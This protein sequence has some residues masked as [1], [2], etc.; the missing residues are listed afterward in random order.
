MKSADAKAYSRYGLRDGPQQ[1][2]DVAAQRFAI[3]ARSSAD[4]CST[5]GLP[6]SMTEPLDLHECVYL[7][8]DT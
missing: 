4:G 2:V 7:T 3:F 1:D 6:R 8:A 5:G